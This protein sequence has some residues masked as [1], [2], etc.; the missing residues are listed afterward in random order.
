MQLRLEATEQTLGT[1]LQFTTF[2]IDASL[3]IGGGVFVN[4]RVD[5]A[6]LGAALAAELAASPC[7]LVSPAAACSVAGDLTQAIFTLQCSPRT[8]ASTAVVAAVRA[9]VSRRIDVRAAPGALAPSLVTLSSS[10]AVPAGAAAV[11]RAQV[12]ASHPRSCH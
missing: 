3:K 6:A 8:A 9:A 4:A 1:F 10:G 2:V 12:G 5:A 7:P 11:A